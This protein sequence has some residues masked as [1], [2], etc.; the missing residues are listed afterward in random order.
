MRV[1]VVEDEKD[2][3][4]VIKMELEDEGYSCDCC[5]DGS[6]ALLYME[7]ADYDVVLMDV[8]LPGQNGF[9]IVRS[10]RSRGGRAPILFLTARD[11]VED[12]VRG[13]D[14][15]AS[16]YII[17]PFSFQELLAR[18]RAAVRSQSGSTGNVYTAADLQLNIQTHEVSRAGKTIRLSAKEFA[19]LEC[20]MK[21]KNTVL[22]R[23]AIENSVYDFD[24]SGGTNVIDVY[25]RY[26]RKK[27]DEGFDKK[28]LH[29]VRG[30]GYVLKEDA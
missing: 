29:T 28:L 15:G 26:L 3:S 30:Y 20:L 8:M 21:N 27:V 22:T 2:L 1:L 9:D 13:L 5:L 19:I 6:D 24:Y 4:D 18:I 10:Y 11:D 17:K 12:R 23:E 16:D 7:S 14:L 25:I